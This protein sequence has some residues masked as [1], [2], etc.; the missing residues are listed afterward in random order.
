MPPAT[1]K[2][3]RPPEPPPDDPPG[4]PF[5]PEPE[6]GGATGPMEGVAVP[7]GPATRYPVTC[8]GLG[9]GATGTGDGVGAWL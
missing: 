9:P 2:A 7:P 1:A 8:S 4:D 5:D 3:I 6:P